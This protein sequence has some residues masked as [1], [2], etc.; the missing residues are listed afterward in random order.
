M[1]KLKC[2]TIFKKIHQMI[3]ENFSMYQSLD[4][5]PHP[6]VNWFYR[7]KYFENYFLF[8]VKWLFP[9]KSTYIHVMVPKVVAMVSAGHL[10]GWDF[11]NHHYVISQ[12]W[13]HMETACYQRIP[14]VYRQQFSVFNLLILSF[15]RFS[16]LQIFAPNLPSFFAAEEFSMIGDEFRCSFNENCQ[17]QCKPNNNDDNNSQ[18]SD[19]NYLQYHY[20]PYQWRIRD[21]P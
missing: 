14:G 16:K 7:K 12:I 19:G 1:V 6:M 13:C 8:Y 11:V 3:L 15:H 10:C 4:T 2:K 17:V 21:F 18:G 9:E 20:V 5:L